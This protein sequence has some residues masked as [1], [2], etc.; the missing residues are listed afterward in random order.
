VPSSPIPV[1]VWLALLRPSAA[2]L[3]VLAEQKFI[4]FKESLSPLY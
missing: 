4:N 2:S 1:D 3:D